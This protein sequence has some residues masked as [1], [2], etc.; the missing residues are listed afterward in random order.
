MKGKLEVFELLPAFSNIC[1]K[2]FGYVAKNKKELQLSAT[3]A[4]FPLETA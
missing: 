1:W 2:L 4:L 3:K